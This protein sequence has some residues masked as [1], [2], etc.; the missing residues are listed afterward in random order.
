[1]TGIPV[2]VDNQKCVCPGV[3]QK[4]PAKTA[5]NG[6]FRSLTSTTAGCTQRTSDRYPAVC[7]KKASCFQRILW[8]GPRR[9]GPN[10]PKKISGILTNS[11]S[12]TIAI[13]LKSG[14]APSRPHQNPQDQAED[15]KGVKVFDFSFEKRGKASVFAGPGLIV[16][17]RQNGMSGDLN[18]PGAPGS[19]AR[20]LPCRTTPGMD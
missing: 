6:W 18:A 1:M 5:P 4:L 16:A 10:C 3:F 7:F 20:H 15:A 11:R 17:R 8:G 14:S 12:C 19:C 9:S 2:L 13:S